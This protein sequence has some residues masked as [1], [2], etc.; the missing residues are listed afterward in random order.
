MSRPSVGL[1]LPLQP[2]ILPPEPLEMYPEIEFVAEGLG[3]ERLTP[4][5]YDRVIDRAAEAAKALRAR[6]VDAI[7]FMG[8]SLS[9]YRGP[10]FN[11]SL[12]ETM[13]AA[14]NLPVKTMSSAMIEAL[15]AMGSRR[16]AIATAY[17]DS[18]NRRLEEFLRDAG[19]AIASLKA[20]HIEDVSL[21]DKI[22]ASDL[23]DLG[24]RAF[25]EDADA[26]FIS[27]GGLRTLEVT[28]P[29]ETR[30]NVPVATSAT[31]GAWAAARLTG[32]SGRAPG[33]GRL[34]Q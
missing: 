9:F 1:I 21:V 4:E 14:T 27:C 19:F 6:N 29:L 25:R 3:L 24:A 20:L 30:F 8:T 2:P 13:H 12:T 34:F 11:N 15:H 28:V 26:I 7:M 33:Y 18:V 17:V 10:A 16:P 32:H 23:I 31:A 5:G 22:A